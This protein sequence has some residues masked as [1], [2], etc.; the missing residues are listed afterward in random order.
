MDGPSRIPGFYPETPV[1]PRHNT[2]NG[3]GNTPT[4]SIGRVGGPIRRTPAVASARNRAY[5]TPYARPPPQ[6][7]PGSGGRPRLD[8]DDEVCLRMSALI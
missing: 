2:V 6:S 7:T 3:H 8:D 4:G 1:V 5:S